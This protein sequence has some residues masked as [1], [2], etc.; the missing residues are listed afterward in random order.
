V[1]YRTIVADPPWEYDS[2]PTD[3]TSERSAFR[4]PG[5]AVD[6]RRRAPLP[7]PSMSVEAVA[8]LPVSDM[9][10]RDAHLY[11]W[12]TQRYLA[13]SFAVVKAWG[14]RYSVTLVWSKSPRGIGPGGTFMPSAEFVIFGRRGT[15]SAL[16]RVDRCVWDWRR[17]L[18]EARRLPR[19]SGVREPRPL[20]R[21]LRAPSAARMGHVGQRGARARH[22]RSREPRPPR[23]VYVS[24]PENTFWLIV[25]ANWTLA[26]RWKLGCLL[27][28][29]K[30]R[31][32]T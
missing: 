20:P 31:G 11:L 22:A 19:P 23:R 27:A 13:D 9:A 18:R 15:C 28:P 21:T 26:E 24:G 7:Y 25:R 12:T 2:W 14:F 6:T 10:E 3:S 17:S 5:V 30:F 4:R 29:E 16:T 1:S 32:C 8:A